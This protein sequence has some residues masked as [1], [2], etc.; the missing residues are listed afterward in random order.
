MSHRNS[1]LLL[2]PL[3]ISSIVFGIILILMNSNVG[4]S[5]MCGR[6]VC[7]QPIIHDPN[8]KGEMIYQGDFKYEANSE[9]PVSTMTF[10][11][12]HD[13][14]LLN[15]ND[16]TVHRILNNTLLKDSLLDVNVANERERGL[17]GIATSKDSSNKTYVYLYYTE[18]EKNDGNDVCPR[19]LNFYCDPNNEPIG[20]R[21]YKYELKNNKLV[22]PKLLLELPAFPGPAHNGGVVT[23]GPD[24]NLYVTIGDLLGSRNINSS[25]R[26]QNFN[27]GT[28]PDGRAGIL[29]IAQDG[30]PVSDGILGKKFPLN[31]YYAYGIRNSFGIDFDPLTGNLWDTENGAEYGDELNL[32]QPGFNS[33]WERI[34]GIWKP[35]PNGT[36]GDEVSSKELP[37]EDFQGRGKYSSPEFIWKDA[38]GVTAAKF[39]N[40]DKLGKKY[41]NDLF[42]ASVTL[43]T[44]FHFDLNKDRTGLKLNGSM[45]DKI[46]DDNTK[47]DD[48]IFVQGLGGIQDIDIGPD[49]YM[50]VLSNYMGKPTI[51]RIV[52]TQSLGPIKSIINL[53][54]EKDIWRPFSHTIISQSDGTLTMSVDTNNTKKIYNRALLQTEINWT[55]SKPLLLNLDYASES[56]KGNATFLAQIRENP[57]VD[58][59]I[60]SKN[61]LWSRYLHNT[62]GKLINETFVLSP[63][64]ANKPVEFRLYIITE[65]AGQHTLTIK[66]ANIVSPIFGIA[67]W[68]LY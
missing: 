35:N 1:V 26:A 33:G 15:K 8:L 44:I 30:S 4:A 37:L 61:I 57:D 23:I 34:Q 29:R 45:S 43:G 20:N 12:P 11:G 51:F 62:S 46:A 42:V 22:N 5:N 66:K 64:I 27:N 55:K 31:L 13:I 65:G 56:L 49:G 52:P 41:E 50:Y 68:Q 17:L 19:N 58:T 21:L 3:F 48:I 10:L 28:D 7:N 67:G 25:T 53:L 9:S 40:S 18:S 2:D 47:L 60:K 36:A 38:M 14:L 39:L 59:T 24:N 63:E 32:V 54:D 16:G 6:V